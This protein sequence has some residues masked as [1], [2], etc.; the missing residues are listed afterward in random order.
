MTKAARPSSVSTGPDDKYPSGPVKH[1]AG[2]FYEFCAKAQHAGDTLQLFCSRGRLC[3]TAQGH[4]RGPADRKKAGTQ[5]NRL[6]RRHRSPKGH[7]FP[8]IGHREHITL[9][10][11]RVG[12][13]EDANPSS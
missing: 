7:R 11:Q 12:K 8:L 5:A 9:L 2:N 10:D 13:V 3:A 6:G 1:L 4:H